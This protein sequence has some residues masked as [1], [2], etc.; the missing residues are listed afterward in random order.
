LT[1]DWAGFWI[2]PPSSSF[3][4]LAKADVFISFIHEEEG[5]AQCVQNL[6]N[7]VLTPEILSFMSSDR[8]QVYARELW[9]E[10]ILD[11]LGPAKVVTGKNSN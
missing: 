2:V 10:R 11:E 6:L 8:F 9:L 3:C 1:G 7:N 5:Y 4:N